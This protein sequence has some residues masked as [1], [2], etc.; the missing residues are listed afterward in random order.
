MRS[1]PQSTWGNVARRSDRQTSRSTIQAG[2]FSRAGGSD[3]AFCDGSARFLKYGAD[4]WPQNIWAVEVDIKEKVASYRDDLSKRITGF[5]KWADIPVDPSTFIDIAAT[6]PA[7]EESAQFDAM[8]DIMLEQGD[9]YDVII[10]DCAAVAN[11]VRLLGLSKI[12][13]LWLVRLIESRKE[14]LSLRLKLSFRKDKVAEEVRKDP[15]LD[16]LLRQRVKMEKARVILNDK[17]K[18]AFVFVTIPL[19]LPIAV[20]QR[21]ITMVRAFD[22]PVGGVF[23]NRVIPETV[24]KQDPTEYM[25]NSFKQ[26]ARY[27]EMIQKQLGD[28]VRAYIPLYSTEVMGVDRIAQVCRDM[29]T[30]RPDQPLKGSKA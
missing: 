16:D 27:M 14:A 29:M 15:L 1:A 19:A 22:I 10:F 26:Q 30:F 24:A 23:V 12:Y 8:T 11:A 25:K 17:E 18:T 4:V 9:K 21:F 2:T 5:L 20:V 13:D 3:Y 7:F 28:L 6:N